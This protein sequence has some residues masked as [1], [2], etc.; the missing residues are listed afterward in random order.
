VSVVSTLG[1]VS[2]L[3]NDFSQGLS[4]ATEYIE[5]YMIIVIVDGDRDA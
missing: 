2:D 1:V 4:T 5:V 3:E